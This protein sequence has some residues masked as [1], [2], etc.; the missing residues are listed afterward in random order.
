[1]KSPEG[2]QTTDDREYP[3]L[4]RATNGKDINISTRVSVRPRSFPVVPN[5]AH[6]SFHRPFIPFMPLTVLC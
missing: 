5:S 3:V 2:E 4:L 1:M 6:R